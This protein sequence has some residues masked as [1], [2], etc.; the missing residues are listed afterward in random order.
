M[1]MGGWT[2]CLPSEFRP[3]PRD[4]SYAA[5]VTRIEDMPKTFDCTLLEA[6]SEGQNISRGKARKAIRL[7]KVTVDGSVVRDPDV[8]VTPMA[9]VVFDPN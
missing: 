8:R 2:S 4:T 7:G 3:N 5:D 9:R 6:I 1:P